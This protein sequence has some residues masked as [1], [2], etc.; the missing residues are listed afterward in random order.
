MERRD[1]LLNLGAPVFVACAACMAA[2][3]KSADSSSSSTPPTNPTPP[4]TGINFSV[5]LNTNLK[6]VFSSVITSGVIVVRIGS[7]N[8]TSDF[9]AVQSAC[10]HQGTT[11]GY[12]TGLGHFLCP[13]HGSEFSNSGAVLV[14]PATTPLK[15]YN[16]AIS[17]TMLTVTG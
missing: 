14:G 13:N 3:S 4:P 2:C 16:V 10:T 8:T 17:G 6:T 12:N 1:F 5:D 9:T 11:I 15:Q 7:G